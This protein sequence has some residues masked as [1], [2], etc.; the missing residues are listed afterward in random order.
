MAAA[1]RVLWVPL[2]A[3]D[4]WPGPPAT[5][6][7]VL[8]EDPG[9]ETPAAG[10]IAVL[11]DAL[12]EPAALDRS[13][14]RVARESPVLFDLPAGPGCKR[15]ENLLRAA[16]FEGIEEAP[17]AGEGRFAGSGVRNAPSL[18]DLEWEQGKPVDAAA[19]LFLRGASRDAE[20]LLCDVLL[21]QNRPFA[22]VVVMDFAREGEE[23]L[24]G[25][26]YGFAA[27]SPADVLHVRVP[28][29]GG[30]REALLEMA[31][32]VGSR[33]LCAGAAGD[34][35]APNWAACAARIF[36]GLPDSESPPWIG[37]ESVTGEGF[38]LDSPGA[39]PRR[40]GSFLERSRL[41]REGAGE[42]FGDGPAGPGEVLVPLPLH[43][44]PGSPSGIRVL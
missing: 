32:E 9:S 38:P 35:F 41:R 2:A 15:I 16:C 33:Y 29:P 14:A 24:S 43:A 12:P 25:D 6:V 19:F 36:E 42:F 17:E 5:G 18:P 27:M 40:R 13:L 21:R 22:E 28:A 31:G 20:L 26:L 8:R 1:D 10:W 39:G 7:E 37:V 44:C 3:G 11:E 30:E 4:R 34:R 23:P